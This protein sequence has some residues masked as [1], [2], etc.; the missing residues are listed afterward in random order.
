MGGKSLRSAA[1]RG[2]VQVGEINRFFASLRPG[3]GATRRSIRSFA[4]AVVRRRAMQARVEV[5]VGFVG[6]VRPGAKDG[7]H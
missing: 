7:T 2:R 6:R 1:F 5:K 3:F 4:D